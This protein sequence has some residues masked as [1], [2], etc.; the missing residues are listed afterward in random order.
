MN[1][2]GRP[3]QIS[4]KSFREKVAY[5]VFRIIRF[6]A[7]FLVVF[8]LIAIMM[9]CISRWFV[10]AF[11]LPIA[12]NDVDFLRYSDAIVG[13]IA[14]ILVIH[15]LKKETEAEKVENRIQQATFVKDYNLSFILDKGLTKIEHELEKY[16]ADYVK[17]PKGANL[18]IGV[19]GTVKRQRFINY[20]VYLESLASIIDHN[21]MTIESIDSLMG[22]RFFLAVNNPVIQREELYQYSLHYRGLFE[23]YEKWVTIKYEELRETIKEAR[24]ARCSAF[25]ESPKENGFY[26]DTAKGLS[27][28]LENNHLEKK[29]I[30]SLKKH[31]R[32]VDPTVDGGKLQQDVPISHKCLGKEHQAD[33]ILRHLLLLIEGDKDSSRN[34]YMGIPMFTPETSLY[35]NA[36]KYEATIGKASRISEI[37]QALRGE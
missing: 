7:W 8:L 36:A 5:L 22:Y 32:E 21:A 1:N 15:Q 2:N 17:N 12:N 23:L 9:N 11:G 29:T 31:Y 35:N 4:T 25:K 3:L 18:N 14:A 16:Y 30:D 13:V 28:A 33:A 34:G 19:E 37:F 27:L 10:F 24:D 26:H 6:V 20:L